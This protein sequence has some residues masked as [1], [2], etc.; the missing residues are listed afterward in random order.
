M[1]TRYGEGYGLEQVRKVMKI[2]TIF[3][4]VNQPNKILRIRPS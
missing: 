4:G 2:I 1:G 3:D